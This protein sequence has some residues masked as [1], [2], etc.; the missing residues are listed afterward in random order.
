MY[1]SQTGTIHSWDKCQHLLSSAARQ[2]S[3]LPWCTWECSSEIFDF[4]K[5]KC[6]SSQGLWFSIIFSNKQTNK[7]EN[8]QEKTT[9]SLSNLSITGKHSV[10]F[11]PAVDP[12]NF[13]LAFY[14]DPGSCIFPEDAVFKMKPE[15]SLPLV[16]CS[17]KHTF[18]PWTGLPQ[19]FFVN[20]LPLVLLT[21]QSI[22]IWAE[23]EDSQT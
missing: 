8:P 4:A 17:H 21:W 13:L 23:L 11:S 5:G 7:Q 1:H 3:Q 19:S 9:T 15:A 18:L 20:S 2:G 14:N 16:V 6:L 12:E 22:Y 10:I